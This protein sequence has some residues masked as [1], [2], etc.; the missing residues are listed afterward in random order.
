MSVRRELLLLAVA[1]VMCGCGGAPASATAARTYS[2]TVLAD[3]PVAYWRMD[4]TTGTTMADATGAWSFTP[5]G[6][7]QG[8]QTLTAAE[9]DL[10]GNIGLATLHFTLDTLGVTGVA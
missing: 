5:T 4:E 10:A 9:T 7:P 1:F 2:A 8:A 3:H 6:L